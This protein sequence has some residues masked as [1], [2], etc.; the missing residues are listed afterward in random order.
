MGMPQPIAVPYSGAS[1]DVNLG[2]RKL[3]ADKVLAGAAAV[4]DSETSNAPL[5]LDGG[6]EGA[7][8]NLKNM[9]FISQFYGGF[10]LSGGTW[11]SGDG[12]WPAVEGQNGQAVLGI[13][14]AYWGAG[15]IFL[16]NRTYVDVYDPEDP[17]Y[18]GYWNPLQA[19][20]YLRPDGTFELGGF[21]DNSAI[22]GWVRGVGDAN[23]YRILIGGPSDD[24]TSKLQVGGTVKATQFQ[25]DAM[26]DVPA[27][28]SDAG[29]PGEIRFTAN[30]IYVCVAANTWKRAALSSW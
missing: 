30:Y 11:L 29:T 23:N 17:Q 5:V 8:L 24:A 20:L 25:V 18:P 12:N 1:R 15:S 28:A 3:S 14:D 21:M 2:S 16:M 6:A 4:D 26:N 27:S 7:L 10:Y 22:P 9:A 19:R 13:N